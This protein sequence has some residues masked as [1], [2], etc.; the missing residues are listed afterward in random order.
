MNTDQNTDKERIAIIT[1]VSNIELFKKTVAFFPE[2][3][4]LF[5]IDGSDGLF[6]LN[7]IKFMFQKLRTKKIKWILMIDEDVIFVN[8]KSI[9]AIIREMQENNYGVAGVRDG[10]ILSW[11][12][13][14]PLLI[15][16][17]FCILDFEKINSIYDE[18]EFMAHNYLIEGEFED[19]LNN[20]QFEYSTTSLF[21]DYYCFFIWL[22]RKKI[23]FKFLSAATSGFENDPETTTVFGLDNEVMLYHTWYARTYGRNEKHSKR[24]D[25]VIS[26]GNFLKGFEDRKIVYLKS[27]IFLFK[28][29]AKKLCNRVSNYFA[30]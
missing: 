27:Y 2:N 30:K 21:E 23:A 10:G 13:K 19:D 4:E 20:L 18:K 7:S 28:K 29:N 14:N 9:L 16:P 26:K 5:A 15:N 1:T 11:R 8:T 25:N 12:D 6:G 22:R 17:F 24:I 3:C